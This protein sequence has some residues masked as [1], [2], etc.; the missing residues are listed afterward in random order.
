M[1]VKHCST[2]FYQEQSHHNC[3]RLSASWQ[4]DAKNVRH[5]G[6]GLVRPGIERKRRRYEIDFGRS[7]ARKF[8]R[9]LVRPNGLTINN[10]KMVRLLAERDGC[11][12]IFAF[13]FL[14]VII[15]LLNCQNGVRRLGKIINP[16]V[17]VLAAPS[18][19]DK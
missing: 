11:T 18:E 9:T 12:R 5:N 13:L 4:V 17:T 14:N 2:G 8:G 16:Y 6:L 3:T 19:F 15:S 1:A 10:K 7:N